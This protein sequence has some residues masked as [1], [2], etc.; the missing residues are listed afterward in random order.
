MAGEYLESAGYNKYEISNFSKNGKES[1]HNL[2][3]WNFDQYLGLGPGAHS[4]L[5][6][7]RFAYGKDVQ[8]YIS[9]VNEGK[10]P[11]KS[12][13]R[14]LSDRDM[15]A[16]SFMLKMRLVKGVKD[17]RDYNI[18]EDM[19]QRYVNGGFLSRDGYATCFTERGFLVSNYILS[20]LISFD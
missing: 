17:F 1:R 3:Y 11:L 20:D 19:I 14:E 4:Y 10:D 15:I 16:E 2:K 6:G 12:E 5:N 13:D 7:K 9:Y 8:K 18:S